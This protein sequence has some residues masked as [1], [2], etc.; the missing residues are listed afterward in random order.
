M[1]GD[2]TLGT[3]IIQDA[4]SEE[5]I[6]EEDNLKKTQRE[7]MFGVL[8]SN[9][10]IHHARDIIKKNIP[11]KHQDNVFHCI[12][13]F[14][15]TL[16]DVAEQLLNLV[17]QKD[18]EWYIDLAY[19]SIY[20]AIDVRIDKTHHDTWNAATPGKQNFQEMIV[21]IEDKKI[22]VDKMKT[23]TWVYIRWNGPTVALWLLPTERIDVHEGNI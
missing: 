6:S 16:P 8:K 14:S 9:M 3:N 17:E 4:N 21:H 5:N 2:E 13:F 20:P 10:D 23:Q 11:E 22:I 19:K 12:W 7:L 1:A 15:T 18:V